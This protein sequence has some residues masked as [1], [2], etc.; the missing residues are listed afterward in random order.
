MDDL[1]SLQGGLA[2]ACI[3]IGSALILLGAAEWRDYR[4]H[5]KWKKENRDKIFDIGN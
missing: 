1:H 2:M 3:T 5:L 4:K